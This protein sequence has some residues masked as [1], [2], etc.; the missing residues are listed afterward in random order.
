MEGDTL[1]LLEQKILKTVETVATLRKDR[2]AA[3]AATQQV[4]ALQSI[5]DEL[6]RELH[7][8]RAERDALKTD[9]E[10]VRKRIEKLLEQIDTVNA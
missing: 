1:T 5:I 8:T 9:R 7:A 4:G 3:V 2:E 10:N 6:N